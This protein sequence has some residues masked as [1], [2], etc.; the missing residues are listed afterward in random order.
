MLQLPVSNC[1][2]SHDERAI[3]NGFGHGFVMLRACEDCGSAY[4]GA[5]VA[6]RGFVRLH[7]AQMPDAEIAH[8]ARGRADVQGIARRDQNDAQAVEFG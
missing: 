5:R 4:G 6:K 2:G 3:G 7:H 1:R 8:G